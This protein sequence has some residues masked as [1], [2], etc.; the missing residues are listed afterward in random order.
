MNWLRSQIALFPKPVLI[1]GKIIFLAGAIM[2]IGAVFARAGLSGV[3]A[4][5]VAAKLPAFTH[6]AQAYPQ[7]PTWLVPE[8]I[9]G[10][11]I[12]GAL[13]LVGTA[14]T[15]LASDVLK[16]KQRIKPW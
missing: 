15:S 12:A 14:L 7:Y 9:V 8:G 5:R 1:I 3:N 10:Y 11:V 6:L 4:D 2:V 16:P 13:V